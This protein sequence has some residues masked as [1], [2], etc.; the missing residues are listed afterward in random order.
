M[1]PI[2]IATTTWSSRRAGEIGKHKREGLGLGL[3]LGRNGIG[4][5][6]EEAVIVGAGARHLIWHSRRKS[7][8]VVCAPFP[9]R[10]RRAG[11]RRRRPTLTQ[12][13]NA[14]T[15]RRNQG[16]KRRSCANLHRE[17]GWNLPRRPANLMETRN[18]GK[19]R[20]PRLDAP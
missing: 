16:G 4:L 7:R 2:Q 1:L 5:K 18:C 9:K 19:L 8:V 14:P 10:R 13:E 15:P 20:Y 11:R 17:A 12:P 6:R 3:S